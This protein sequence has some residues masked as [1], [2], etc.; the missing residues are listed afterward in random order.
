MVVKFREIGNSMGITIPKDIVKSFGIVQGEEADIG[1]LNDSIIIKPLIQKKKVTIKS[2]F[3]GY[4]GSYK[5]SEI[6][7]GTLRGKEVW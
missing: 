4:T 3:D 2:L 7:W 6:T 5:P 1:V